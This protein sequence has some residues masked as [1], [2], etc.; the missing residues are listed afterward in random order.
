MK[1]EKYPFKIEGKEKLSQSN[2]MLLLTM[3]LSFFAFFTRVYMGFIILTVY[4]DDLPL[5][6]MGFFI[7]IIGLAG[8]G[9]PLLQRLFKKYNSKKQFIIYGLA[10]LVTL[11][12]IFILLSYKTFPFIFIATSILSSLLVSAM[13]VEF[14]VILHSNNASDRQTELIEKHSQV[15]IEISYS[16]CTL[17]GAI[18]ITRFDFQYIVLLD[19]IT[20]IFYISLSIYMMNKYNKGKEVILVDERAA[21]KKLNYQLFPLKN[22]LRTIFLFAPFIAATGL[23]VLFEGNDVIFTY[24]LDNLENGI[25]LFAYVNIFA[26]TVGVI[27]IHVADTFIKSVGNRILLSAII[28]FGNVFLLVIVPTNPMLLIP[29][30]VISGIGVCVM[31]AN[32]RAYVLKH[33]QYSIKQSITAIHLG[34]KIFVSI[35]QMLFFYLYIQKTSFAYIIASGIVFLIVMVSMLNVKQKKMP[36][37]L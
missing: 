10:Y 3:G 2:K 20:N 31:L 30:S 21:K 37:F 34:N 9:V 5:E 4:K 25:M 19:I 18:V 35:A 29:Y 12:V 24:I 26:S 28:M 14:K 8:V 6:L 13:T 33:T 7:G 1:K 36:N 23:S 16:L 32:V 11:F 22:H 15:V 17:V 27:A